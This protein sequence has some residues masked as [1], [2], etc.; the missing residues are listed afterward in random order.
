MRLSLLTTVSLQDT[1]MPQLCS[2]SASHHLNVIIVANKHSCVYFVHRQ[3]QSMAPGVTS[4]KST[5]TRTKLSTH[6]RR[7]RL[8]KRSSRHDLE[9]K[10]LRVKIQVIH[11]CVQIH[12]EKLH[13][14]VRLIHAGTEKGHNWFCRCRRTHRVDKEEAANN[15]ELF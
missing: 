4:Y 13:R 5:T 2:T 12:G 10:L 8:R 3:Q 15:P 11:P 6:T 9:R 1:G 14:H 7:R